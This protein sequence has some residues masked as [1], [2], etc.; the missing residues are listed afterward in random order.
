[1]TDC[2]KF[3]ISCLMVNSDKGRKLL[4][5]INEEILLVP[6]KFKWIAERNKTLERPTLRP[7][8]RDKLYKNINAMGYQKWV[9]KYFYSESYLIHIKGFNILIKLKN[10]ILRILK[11]KGGNGL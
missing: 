5:G 10:K 7:K 9:K 2:E 11:Y 8:E 1:M 3:A 6:S 4:N